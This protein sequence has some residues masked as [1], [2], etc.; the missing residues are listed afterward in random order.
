MQ[1]TILYNGDTPT[2]VPTHMV[3]N[4]K[5][6][7]YTD[8]PRTQILPP[9][10]QQPIVANQPVPTALAQ[11]NANLPPVIN[12][13]NKVATVEVNLAELKELT[14]GLGLTTA[15]AK[16]VVAKR[17]Y[18]NLDDLIVKLP[19]TINWAEYSNLGY[20]LPDVTDSSAS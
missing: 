9:P 5:R 19:N 12:T 4:F 3:G 7:G 20:A 6:Q 1:F 14:S 13:G 18:V 10:V 8:K 16:Q 11:T 17:P 2:Q 15:M